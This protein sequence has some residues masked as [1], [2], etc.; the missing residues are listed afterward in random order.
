MELKTQLITIM[1][2]RIKQDIKKFYFTHLE[3]EAS[4]I[5]SNYD[6]L[7]T[8]INGKLLKGTGSISVNDTKYCIEILYSPFF[9]LR[10]DRIRITNHNIKYHDDIHVYGDSS[11]CLYHPIIDKPLFGIVP[12]HKMIPWI[13]EWCHFYGEW[14]KY[15]VWLAPEIKHRRI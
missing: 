9:P 12:L 10:M 11:L 8:S 2:E 14:K 7:K 5:R 1:E 15:G 3:V 6:W 4:I 13:T